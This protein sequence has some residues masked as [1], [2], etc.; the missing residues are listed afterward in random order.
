MEPAGVSF[1]SGPWLGCATRL[2]EAL[3]HL[4]ALVS[5]AVRSFTDCVG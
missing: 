3:L 4:S 1:T 5:F 2:G